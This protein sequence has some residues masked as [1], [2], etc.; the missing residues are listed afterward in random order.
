MRT[1]SPDGL[2]SGGDPSRAPH[3]VLA[4]GIETAAAVAPAFTAEIQAGE[5][6]V[7]AA[8][9]ATGIAIHARQMGG[10]CSYDYVWQKQ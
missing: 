3:I 9:S 10:S 1:I 2:L 4:E 7:A 8:I 5:I 6:A